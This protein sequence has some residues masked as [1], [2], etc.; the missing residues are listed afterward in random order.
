[1]RQHV[2]VLDTTKRLLDRYYATVRES[3]D[4][5]SAETEDL[6]YAV[7]YW[8]IGMRMNLARTHGWKVSLILLIR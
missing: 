7:I 3:P 5:V 1:M 2:S 4:R 8:L 6:A